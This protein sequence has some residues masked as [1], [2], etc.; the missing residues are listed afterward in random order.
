MFAEDKGLF[1]QLHWEFYLEFNTH[2]V[3]EGKDFH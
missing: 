3:S 1:D 2:T